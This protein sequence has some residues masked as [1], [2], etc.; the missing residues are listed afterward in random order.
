MS[1]CRV[2]ETL[3]AAVIPV[4]SAGLPAHENRSQ[5]RFLVAEPVFLILCRHVLPV[6]WVFSL[7]FPVALSGHLPHFRWGVFSAV[8]GIQV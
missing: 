6:A 4:V 2:L 1:R 5:N 3:H 8:Q 7:V